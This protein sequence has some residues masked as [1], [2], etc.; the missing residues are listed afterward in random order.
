MDLSNMI[1]IL[2]AN[3]LLVGLFFYIQAKKE[4]LKLFPDTTQ[5]QTMRPGERLFITDPGVE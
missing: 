1:F 5:D 4:R 3:A 2:S